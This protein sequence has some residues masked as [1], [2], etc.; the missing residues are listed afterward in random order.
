MED[1]QFSSVNNALH[2]LL[3]FRTRRLLRVTDVADELGVARS[4]AH[5][6]LNALVQQGFA[7]Q[8]TVTRAYAPG[9]VLTEIG[10]AVV[11][12][13]DIRG[14]ARPIMKQ[15]SE[16]FD[17]TVSLVMLK[18]DMANFLD[19]IESSRTVRV[20]SRT[21]QMLPANCVS[22]GK[23]LLSTLSARQLDAIYPGDNLPTMTAS[24]F[25]TKKALVREL[26]QIRKQGYSTN[27]AES[28]PDVTAAAALVRLAGSLAAVTVAA[29]TSRLPHSKA[30]DL[31]R[32]IVEV[33]NSSEGRL[34]ELIP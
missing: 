26:E 11:S 10:M 3:L 21:G 8:D 9:S 17:E 15:L 4:T 18:G 33:V 27:K 32:S 2:V 14:Y 5:R 25:N 30:D 29:P 7:A 28:E 6:L 19:S 22:G 31:G 34:P 13:L 24:S 23:A 20:G 12:M 16:M 1:K